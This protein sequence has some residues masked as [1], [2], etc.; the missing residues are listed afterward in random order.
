MDDSPQ[1]SVLGGT[2]VEI[3]SH[4]S[5]SISVYAALVLLG[6]P[7]LVGFGKG[8]L[9]PSYI[10]L[11]RLILAVLFQYSVGANHDDR[12]FFLSF[13]VVII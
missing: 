1:F 4:I 8:H 5:T 3:V 12:I 9:L 6:G 13:Y 10:P 7:L 11:V 2:L